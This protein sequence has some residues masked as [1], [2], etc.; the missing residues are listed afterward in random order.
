MRYEHTQTGY[1]VIWALL[2]ASVLVWVGP[3]SHG[4]PPSGSSLVLPAV[5]LTTIALF[6]KLTIEIDDPTLLA[7]FG[8]GLIR[9]K[10]PLAEIVRCEP[11]RIRWWYGWGIHLTPH[12]WLYNV[13]GWDAVAITLRDGRKFALGTDDPYG[14][15][16]AIRPLMDE[17]G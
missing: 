9:K 4:S 16:D 8:I 7:S 13:A 10:V 2:G 14:L 17:Q 3:I 6:Y 15:A 1:V 12:G 5:F 11:I